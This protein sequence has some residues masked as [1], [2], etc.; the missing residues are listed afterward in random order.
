MNLR[1]LSLIAILSVLVTGAR[2]GTA[3][4]TNLD[5]VQVL[6]EKTQ[7]VALLGQPDG[8]DDLDAGLRMDVYRI[9]AAPLIGAGFIY[10]EK[11]RV[12]GQAYIFKG[13]GASGAADHLKKIGFTLLESE[14]GL[15][16]LEGK[17]DDTGLPLVVTISESED[18]TTLMA[19]EKTFYRAHPLRRP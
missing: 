7:V 1:I 5:K 15:F 16:R 11:Q 13:R 3:D 2:A 17:D 4:V 19:F 12:A 18:M 14:Q 9:E 8:Q 10:D 6:M